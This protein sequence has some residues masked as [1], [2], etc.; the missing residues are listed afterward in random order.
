MQVDGDAATGVDTVTYAPGP[1]TGEGRA[2]YT[3]AAGGTAMTIDFVNLEPFE[4]NVAAANLVVLGSP[5]DNAINYN[6]GPNSGMAA[7][8]IFMGAVTGFVTI[9]NF[10]ARMR[11]LTRQLN[12]VLK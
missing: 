7:H 8:P 1:Q 4:D 12:R 10:E 5:A 3:T 2:T 6:R 11:A 9:D